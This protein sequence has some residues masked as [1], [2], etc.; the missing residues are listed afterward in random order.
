MGLKA[1][2]LSRDQDDE[3][4]NDGV[5]KGAYQVVYFTPEMLLGSKKWRK[6]VL[7]DIYTSR[8]RAFI[9]DEAHT[10]VKW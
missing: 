8:L 3:G 2:H 9:I 6:M 1:C 5:V 10:V 7:D 4:V